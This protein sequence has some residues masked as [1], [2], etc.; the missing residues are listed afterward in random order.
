MHRSRLA[1]FIIDCRTDDLDQA[2]QFWGEALGYPL[3]RPDDPAE[4][5][6]IHLQTGP[7]EMHIEVQ[8]VDHPSRVHLDI[9]TDDIDAEVAR[10]EQLGAKR[11]A[12]VKT[13]VVMEAPTGQRF[14][15][16]RPQRDDFAV[17]ANEW[18]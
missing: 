17:Q 4:S 11:I 9:E 14:C 7:D 15:V 13:W 6:Y 3:H 2:A 18:Q 16:V 12:R 8:S 10:L 1:G 5:S